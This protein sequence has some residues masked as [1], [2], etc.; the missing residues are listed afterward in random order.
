MRRRYVI[1]DRRVIKGVVHELRRVI[2]T[3]KGERMTLA[4]HGREEREWVSVTP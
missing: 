1:G 4:P 2:V 3:W